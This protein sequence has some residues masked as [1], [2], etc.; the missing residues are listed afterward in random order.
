MIKKIIVYTTNDCIECT[1]VK[2]VLEE[3]GIPVEL[4]DLSIN[5]NFQKEVEQLG[6]MGVPVTVL[7]NRAIKGFTNEL[8]ELIELA[9][10]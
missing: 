2:K 4:R 8:K 7:E 6:F 9:K 1:M 5:P 3:E 10:E